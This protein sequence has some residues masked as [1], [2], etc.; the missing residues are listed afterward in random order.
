MTTTRYLQIG[1][2]VAL[3]ALAAWGASRLIERMVSPQPAASAAPASA[4]AA[5]GVPH[6]IATLYYATPDGQALAAVKL[7][8]EASGTPR[9]EEEIP[10]VEMPADDR[11]DGRKAKPRDQRPAVGR[12]QRRGRRASEATTRL[13]VSTGRSAG[14]GRGDREVQR[15]RARLLGRGVWIGASGQQRGDRCWAA[16]ADGA[17]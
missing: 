4:T 15:G 12:D 9:E 17:V 6:I 2:G 14:P 5:A 10:A 1:G 16:R 13:F 11:R 3:V 8:H 7:A